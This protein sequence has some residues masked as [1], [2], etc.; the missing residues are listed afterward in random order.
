MTLETRH[1]TDMEA[2]DAV[3]TGHVICGRSFCIFK[4]I[5]HTSYGQ[6]VNSYGSF[7]SFAGP[8]TR[9]NSNSEGNLFHQD[10]Y[11]ELIL[12]VQ[13]T[14]A[15]KYMSEAPPETSFGTLVNQVAKDIVAAEKLRV[16]ESRYVQDR[17]TTSS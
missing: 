2:I 5:K 11:F 3:D 17:R 4:D 6:N 7:E 16:L 9:G 8:W 13:L 1:I 10:T 12:N 15:I 14:R